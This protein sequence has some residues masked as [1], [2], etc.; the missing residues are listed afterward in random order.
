MSTDD[1]KLL[2]NEYFNDEV[3]QDIKEYVEERYVYKILQEVELS[4]DAQCILDMAIELTKESFKYRD[5]F[6]EDHP[7][8]YINT[9]DAG[10]YQI[11]A[12]LK[13]YMPN[14]LKEFNEMYK[15]LGDR[16]RPLVYELGF[17]ME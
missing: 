10:W 12:L 15:A 7:E 13:E 14:E 6:N 16:M 3:Y 5:M 17:L 11:K 2:A 9:W 1:M 8:Y 4:Q